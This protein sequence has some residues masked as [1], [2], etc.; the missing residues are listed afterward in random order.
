[1]TDTDTAPALVD[2]VSGAVPVEWYGA[3]RLAARIYNTPFVPKALRGDPA[4]VLA[5]ILTG[6]ELGLEAMQSLRMVNVIEG[7][8]AASA[9]LMR[10]L[11]HRAGHLIG[12]VDSTTERCEMRGQRDDTGETMTVEWTLDDARRAGLI[13]A[14]P[15]AAW[16]KYPRSMLLARATSE[17]CR[18]LFSD[19]V[20]GLY[21]PEETVAMNGHP[22][23][24]TAGELVDPITGPLPTEAQLEAG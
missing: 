15:E 9:E 18:A 13:P 1:M 21:T 2:D 24:A 6:Q 16:T 8:P 20:G 7:K 4:S 3:M 19:V 12:I 11:V 14:K 5:C 23:E 17:L 10:A 22:Y